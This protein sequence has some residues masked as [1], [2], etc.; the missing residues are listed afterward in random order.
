MILGIGV[1]VLDVH[2]VARR[3]DGDP[4]FAAVFTRP[5][6]LESLSAWAEPAARAALAF[7]AKEAVLKVLRVEDADGVLFRDIELLAGGR[8]P[9]VRLHERAL[10]AARRRGIGTIHVSLSTAEGS[11]LA[12]AV[13]EGDVNQKES[14]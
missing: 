5:G 3:I 4:A 14:A 11:A 13:G 7:A 6:E 1:D 10:A 9:A 12:V 8:R 2:R